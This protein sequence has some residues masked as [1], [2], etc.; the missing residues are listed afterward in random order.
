MGRNRYIAVLGC[1]LTGSPDGLL[2]PAGAGAGAGAGA[3][4][5]SDG[6]ALTTTRGDVR[7]RLWD[8][9]TGQPH[10]KP[11]IG[12]SNSIRSVMFS[13]DSRLLATASSDGTA[14]LW[15][16]ATQPHPG[17]RGSGPARPSTTTP[18]T[19]AGPLG[20]PARPRLH[21]VTGAGAGVSAR[22]RTGPCPRW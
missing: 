21:L 16:L 1:T 12:H 10:G 20:P 6:R 13:P 5:A 17:R 8:P 14:R 11:L 7:V 18:T 19:A 22:W 2:A 3:P 9:V 15:P 4:S